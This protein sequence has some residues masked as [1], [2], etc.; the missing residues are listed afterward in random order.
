MIIT[1]QDGWREEKVKRSSGCAL[2][3]ETQQYIRTIKSV[4]PQPI[5]QVT[6]VIIDAPQARRAVIRRTRNGMGSR[7]VCVEAEFVQ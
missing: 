6:P 3:D 4:L 7:R 2:A 1:V 5:S